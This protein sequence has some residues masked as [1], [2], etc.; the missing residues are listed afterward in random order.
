MQKH[1]FKDHTMSQLT[2]TLPQALSSDGSVSL[3]SQLHRAER[4]KKLKYG[5]LI[6]PLVVFLLFTFIWPIAALL[7]R[8]VDNPEIVTAFPATSA[9]LGSKRTSPATKCGS[10]AA[11]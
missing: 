9:L 11:M 6:L 7:K 2:A 3:K 1:I 10:A 4:M 5:A 8:S